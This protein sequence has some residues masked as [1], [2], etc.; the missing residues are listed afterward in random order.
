MN[1]NISDK[2]EASKIYS[3]DAFYVQVGREDF[4]GHPRRERVLF[5][6]HAKISSY[7]LEETGR[8]ESKDIGLLKWCWH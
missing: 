2:F 3:G 7:K 4:C 8:A 5:G 1:A 6:L